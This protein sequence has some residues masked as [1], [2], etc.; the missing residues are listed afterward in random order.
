MCRWHMHISTLIRTVYADSEKGRF[1]CT[2]LGCRDGMKREKC[3]ALLC[4]R[5]HSPYRAGDRAVSTS[6]RTTAVGKLK[7]SFVLSNFRSN[8]IADALG[9][10]SRSPRAR[11]LRRKGSSWP[12]NL[13]LSGSAL[14]PIGKRS[15]YDLA[16][17]PHSIVR[18][19]GYPISTPFSDAT[20]A[21]VCAFLS[22]G[23]LAR[24]LHLLPIEC[25][26]HQED[27]V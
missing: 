23:L 16:R 26:R 6:R 8:G 21:G 2:N 18:V 1:V 14:D 22:G 3:V 7:A 24:G 19:K 5:I 10:S 4:K 13:P 11:R 25:T 27:I 12:A 15:R 9:I 17:S 20:Y